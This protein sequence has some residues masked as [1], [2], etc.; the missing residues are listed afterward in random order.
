MTAD[1]A[2]IAPMKIIMMNFNRI[3]VRSIYRPTSK[4]HLST[5]KVTNIGFLEVFGEHFGTVVNHTQSYLEILHGHGLTWWGCITLSALSLRLLV[6]P[7]RASALVHHA[8]AQSASQA[9]QDRQ[10]EL[11]SHI[12]KQL[13]TIPIP[14][15]QA[16]VKAELTRAWLQSLR[17]HRT[18]PLRGLLPLMLQLPLLLTMTATLRK[19]SAYPWPFGDLVVKEGA[20]TMTEGWD[21]GGW[22]GWENLAVPNIGLTVVVVLS[23][24]ATIE[25]IFRRDEPTRSSRGRTILRWLMH[26]LNGFSLYLLSMLPT[27]INW[28]ILCNNGLTVLEGSL[29]RSKLIKKFIERF[30]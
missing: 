21:I 9:L 19:M 12:R 23:N 3:L 6:L 16:F 18:H 1:P 27:A 17:E 25:W 2:I 24:F 26:G 4:R 28:F 22:W 8:R 29:L 30:K 13:S 11:H 5:D 15:R 20:M 14:S 7:A 10:I